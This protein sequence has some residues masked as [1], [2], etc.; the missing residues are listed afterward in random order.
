MVTAHI[1][2]IGY[3]VYRI[4]NS[5]LKL[6]KVGS[7][8]E[9]GRFQC[10]LKTDTDK[11]DITVLDYDEDSDYADAD[12][13]EGIWYKNIQVG[14]PIYYKNVLVNKPRGKF[15]GAGLDNK[16]GIAVVIKAMQELSSM[17]NLDCN[18][19][20]VLPAME[21]IGSYGSHAAV[22]KIKPTFV[23]NIDVFPVS[24]R[25]ELSIGTIILRGSVLNNELFRYA[26][27]EAVLNKIPY[28]VGVAR[29][30][31]LSCVNDILG[32]NGG[33]PCCELGI[34]CLNLHSPNEIVSKKS[35]N[36][37]TKLL[38]TLCS[39]SKKLK[40]LVPGGNNGL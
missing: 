20:F 16:S 33:T 1:D 23:I 30:D 17:K 14:D 3:L 27:N 29:P 4:N 9:E 18:I 34:P 8:N 2:T 5:T 25:R 12:L 31:D 28:E 19:F 38:V 11:Y 7:P 35:I 36:S 21:E 13:E 24:T 39:S 37:T 15:T 32:V 6:V 26:R 40:S 22:S 10:T